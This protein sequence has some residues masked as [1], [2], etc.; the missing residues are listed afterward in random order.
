MV[1]KSSFAAYEPPLS[2]ILPL[3]VQTGYLT[4]KDTVMMGQ[5]RFYELDYP[6][7]EV[8]RSL[9]QHLLK[10]LAEL[11]DVE[12]EVALRKL[13][14]ALDSG[15]VDTL[16]KQVKIFFKGI[17]YDIQLDNKKYYQSLF[18]ALFRV[19]VQK[20][21]NLNFSDEICKKAS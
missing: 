21:E 2:T 9:S 17:P 15:D 7:Q 8:E 18:V 14:Q 19:L 12:M 1:P 10:G 3:L 11:P 13:Y 16:L 5:E 6:N 4:I 20:H